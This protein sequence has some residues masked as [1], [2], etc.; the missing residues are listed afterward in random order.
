MHGE[1][2]TDRVARRRDRR[3]LARL[4]RGALHLRRLRQQLLHAEL[5][6]AQD[7]GPHR[8][9]GGLLRIVRE[10]EE[11]RA[12]G[13][14]SAAGM[15]VISEHRCADHYDHVVAGQPVGERL[16]QR[17]QEPGEQRV[18]LRE[19]AA[20]GH[21]ALPDRGVE[22]LGEL[23]R[24]RPRTV[25]VHG[26]TDHQRRTTARVQRVG[27]AIERAGVGGKL[28]IDLT[29][30]D[31][32][33]LHLPV[34]FGNRYEHRAARPLQGGMDGLGDRGGHVL[35]ACR[36]DAPFDVGPWKLDGRAR[37][38]KRIGREHGARLLAGDDDQRSLVAV[39][40]EHA[41]QR[42][43]DASGRMQVHQRS[44]ARDLGI[45]VGH[46]HNHAFLQPQ[47]I[48]EVLRP[49]AEHAQLGRA[50]V[51]EDG[52]HAERAQQIEGRLP[53]ADLVTGAVLS[54]DS[55]QFHSVLHPL[56]STS[57]FGECA[58]GHCLAHSQIAMYRIGGSVA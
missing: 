6:G 50:R 42:V 38:Q 23:D 43:P 3:P 27:Q 54:A 24:E 48:V 34:I 19:A 11:L 41:A 49:V 40:G 45:A 22:T 13:Q 20:P 2:A 35:A 15:D 16:A 30:L 9:A 14:E 8:R 25:L 29:W 51:A 39:G 7:A 4:R 56:S 36:L 5:N 52:G 53:H 1:L 46:G 55:F 57:A 47:H 33:R 18:V 58:P 32:V 31:R 37:G 44:A 28:D 21:R 12:L 26:S 10:M 17:R